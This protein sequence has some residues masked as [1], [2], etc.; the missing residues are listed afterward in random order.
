MQTINELHPN[1]LIIPHGLKEF[2]GIQMLFIPYA[3]SAIIYK[4]LNYELDNVEF[5]TQSHCIVFSCGGVETISAYDFST[6]QIAQHEMLFLPKDMY[7]ISD[8]TK[9]EKTLKA[10]MF[11]FDDNIIDTFLSQKVLNENSYERKV[12]F[13][14]IEINSGIQNYINTLKSVSENQYHSK[15]FLELKLLELLHIV[16]AN[17]KNNTL[18]NTL[19]SV[20]KDKNKRNIT[21]LMKRHFLSSL[22]LED[23]ARLSGRSLSSFYRDFKQNNDISPKQ[24]L[25]N[26]KLDYAKDT[27]QKEDINISK[28]SI[29][30][31]YKN[32][33]HFIKAFKVRFHQ[34]PKQFSK[35]KD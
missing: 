23:F 25:I 31:G 8:Y 28:L 5:Y 17:D 19:L 4:E 33:S 13:F 20:N 7:L 9:P 32:L 27:L 2:N 12:S 16:D 24:Y 3:N 11:F 29:R 1:S 26:L 10:Y 30:L 35:Q 34:T 22:T 15:A 6:I 18:L 14:K 21:S